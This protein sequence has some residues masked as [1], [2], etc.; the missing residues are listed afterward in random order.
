M[1]NYFTIASSWEVDFTNCKN[2]MRG[3]E[4][5]TIVSLPGVFVI[6]FIYSMVVMCDILR[7]MML[8][9]ILGHLVATSILGELCYSFSLY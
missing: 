7:I 3:M 8:V 4:F 5:I 1:G 6:L 9:D 2:S